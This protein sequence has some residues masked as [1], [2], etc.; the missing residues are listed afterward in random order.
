[1]EKKQFH[2]VC[3][4]VYRPQ[5]YKQLK[6]R[7]LFQGYTWHEKQL[8]HLGAKIF[9]WIW[10]I[11]KWQRFDLICD[12]NH[13]SMAKIIKILFQWELFWIVLKQRTR[14]TWSMILLAHMFGKIPACSLSLS[15][16]RSLTCKSAITWENFDF[17]EVS[18]SVT[19]MYFLKVRCVLQTD[20]YFNYNLRH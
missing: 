18:K 19:H 7:Y 17:W 9:H 5:I 6:D 10:F 11:E 12:Y 4:D 16:K 2:L 13:F 8:K 1:M 3:D 15:L 20:E 14:K